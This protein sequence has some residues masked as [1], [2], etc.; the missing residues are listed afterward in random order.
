MYEFKCA[1]QIFI[2]HFLAIKIVHKFHRDYFVMC[3]KYKE[4]LGHS[5]IKV[6]TKRGSYSCLALT[7]INLYQLFLSRT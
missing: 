7:L 6:K 2:Y 4:F 3:F 1:F 5:V